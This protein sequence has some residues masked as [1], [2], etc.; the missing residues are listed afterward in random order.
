M[1]SMA[2][3]CSA[4]SSTLCESGADAANDAARLCKQYGHRS[5]P[6]PE[7][8]PIC[9]LE[10]AIVILGV[11]VGACAGLA[12]CAILTWYQ[13]LCYVSVP[14]VLAAAYRLWLHARYM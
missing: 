2:P 14:G 11:D 6:A 1:S 10:G 3:S 9:C 5:Q 4:P 13:T 8:N 7:H 12:C